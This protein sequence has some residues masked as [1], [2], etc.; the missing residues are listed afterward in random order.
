MSVEPK[1]SPRSSDEYITDD[2]NS[3]SNSSYHQSQSP[4]STCSSSCA[5]R[6]IPARRGHGD[7]NADAAAA[8]D[9]AAVVE[10][11]IREEVLA[12][13]AS[14]ST[15]LHDEV[16]RQLPHSMTLG[17]TDTWSYGDGRGVPPHRRQHDWVAVANFHFGCVFFIGVQFRFPPPPPL[18]FIL[19]WYRLRRAS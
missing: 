1:T 16:Q 9:D 6:R 5:R 14:R 18:I 4:S 8:D 2:S 3:N 7:G 19:L 17:H 10:D 11:G 12:R 13:S 15:T